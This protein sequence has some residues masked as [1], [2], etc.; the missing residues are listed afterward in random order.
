M[1]KRGWIALT[2]SLFLAAAAGLG[3]QNVEPTVTLASLPQNVEQL[4]TLRETLGTQPSGAAALFAAALIRYAEDQTAGLPMLVVMLVNDG[5]LMSTVTGN[6]GYRGYD[7]TASTRY[8]VD[9]L[10]DQPWIAKSLVQG[11]SPANRYAIPSGPARFE[12]SKNPYTLVSP[13]E[14]RIFIS[15]TGADSARPLRLKQNE[16]GLWK[17][18]EFSSL[19]V[20]VRA[21]ASTTRDDL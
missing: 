19:V 12:F 16:A 2:L 13:T 15:S 6:R 8:L 5:S 1:Q 7:L 17:V 4:L 21:P 14:L 20:G 11:T 18:A 10:K 9:R 3:A